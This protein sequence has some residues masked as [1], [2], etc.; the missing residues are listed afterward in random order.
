MSGLLRLMRRLSSVLCLAAL[1]KAWH[2][3][4]LII[5]RFT[6]LYF[7]EDDLLGS[8][9]FSTPRSRARFSHWGV[10]PKVSGHGE[11]WSI[12]HTSKHG[13]EIASLTPLTLTSRSAAA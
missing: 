2:L 5:S 11:T 10:D 9:D 4:P 13:L 8:V 7:D 12:S 1:T 6:D 3:L